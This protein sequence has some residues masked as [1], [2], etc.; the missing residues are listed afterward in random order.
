MNLTLGQFHTGMRKSGGHTACA[1]LLFI[2]VSEKRLCLFDKFQCHCLKTSYSLCF[3]PLAL[4]TLLMMVVMC[5]EKI[6]LFLNRPIFEQKSKVCANFN[7]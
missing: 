6:F 3:I 1:A 5:N 7:V 4:F 2:V